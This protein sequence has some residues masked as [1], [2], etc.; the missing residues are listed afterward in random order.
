MADT[1]WETMT[2]VRE[3]CRRFR[4]PIVVD[5]DAIHAFADHE[6]D[7]EAL[8]DRVLVTPHPGEF[9]AL[10]GEAKK[11]PN[12]ADAAAYAAAHGINVLL[13]GRPTGDSPRTRSV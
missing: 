8:G 2:A 12:E 11:D 9:A 1:R 7:L 5:A 3:A 4:G 13:K 6:A 10:A